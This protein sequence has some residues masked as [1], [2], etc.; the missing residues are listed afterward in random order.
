MTHVDEVAIAERTRRL[1]AEIPRT[2]TVVA[3]AKT[4]TPAEVRAALGA[5]I[6]AV[7]E[8]YV[9]EA[10]KAQAALGRSAAKWHLIGHLQRNKA[11]A[12]VRLFDL[13]QT[14]DSLRLGEALDAAS[15]A[16]GR[17]MPILV[18]VNGGREPQKAGVWPEDA[19]DLVRAL[20]R[21]GALR[22]VGLMTMGPLA[23]DPEAESGALRLAFR[24]TRALFETLRRAPF[25]RTRME[26]LSMGMSDSYSAAI[27]EG[28]T[29]VRIGTSLFGPRGA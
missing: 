22:V 25:E 13:I 15:R 7:G 9:Q 3:A 19:L 28:A 24:E 26:I 16:V 21:L 1:L 2:V 11:K 12:A 29:M 8:N 10:E 27:A 23:A 18:E 6:T 17:E 4:R 20:D 5:G 14:V